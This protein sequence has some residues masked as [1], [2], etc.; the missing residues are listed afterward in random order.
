MIIK[1]E[2]AI[3]LLSVKRNGIENSEESSFL[4]LERMNFL[5]MEKPFNY[6]LTYWGNILAGI[7]D[8]MVRKEVIEHPENW[9]EEFRWLSSEVIMMIETAMKSEDIPG[10]L[11]LEELKK[12]GFTEERKIE[13][14]E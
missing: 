4:E 11:T 14:I 8:E 7:L 10:K 1:K 12:R 13:K 9:D 6:S 2:H 3:A 5:R